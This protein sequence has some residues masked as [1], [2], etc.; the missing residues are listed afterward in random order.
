MSSVLQDFLREQGYAVCQYHGG[1]EFSLLCPAP[2]WFKWIWGEPAGE[3][4]ILRLGDKSP[5]LENFLVEAHMFWSDAALKGGATEDAL[6]PSRK[7]AALNSG[8]WVEPLRD[9]IGMPYEISLQA[10]ALK[11]G[12]QCL[13]SVQNQAE[14]AAEETRILQTA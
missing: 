6:V 14:T 3:K 4:K 7:T 11:M 8:L 1:G 10:T 12:E 2:D 5:F 9:E 13:L